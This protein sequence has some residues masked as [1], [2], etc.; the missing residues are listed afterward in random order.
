MRSLID[1]DAEVAEASS[2]EESDDEIEDDFDDNGTFR[3][4]LVQDNSQHFRRRRCCA[5]IV[6]LMR[7][8]HWRACE[9]WDREV[10]KPIFI[11]GSIKELPGGPEEQPAA[12][13]NFRMVAIG[14]DQT[15]SN[16]SLSRAN[17]H[18]S[19]AEK[20]SVDKLVDIV[21]NKERY[22]MWK[23]NRILFST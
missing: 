9:S 18:I 22:V 14:A 7:M 2:G 20:K 4:V 15:S 8:E 5:P 6:V 16:F 11:E 17:T 23:R 10:P 13:T 1:F 21:R 3:R 19:I 12:E